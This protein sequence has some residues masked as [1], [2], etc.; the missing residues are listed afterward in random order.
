M[1]YKL[2]TIF[3]DKRGASGAS[4]KTTILVVED[5]DVDRRFIQ[6]TLAKRGYRVVTAVN[7][8]A[9]LETVKSENPDLIILDCQMPVM[10]GLEM[11]KR[12][13]ENE[14]TGEIPVIFLTALDTPQNIIDCFENDCE[15]YLSKPIS[16]K[17]LVS[18]VEAIL[19]E[20]S[21]T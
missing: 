15:I 12:L 21:S 11:C 1:F 5:T 8:A 7:G 2:K 13:K 18:Q 10:D 16:G 3:K 17:L 4:S 20:Y 9:G 14:K 6:E 19:K